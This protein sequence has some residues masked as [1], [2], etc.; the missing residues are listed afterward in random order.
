MFYVRS[1]S[2]ALKMSSVIRK[3]YEI[4]VGCIIEMKMEENSIKIVMIPSVSVNLGQ[5]FPIF[6]TKKE[7]KFI[8]ISTGLSSMT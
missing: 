7:E 1:V 6:S 2:N 8:K 3:A 5:S 4:S